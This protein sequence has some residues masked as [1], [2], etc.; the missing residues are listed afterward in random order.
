MVAAANAVQTALQTANQGESDQ[1]RAQ[2]AAMLQWM[3][4]TMARGD[5]GQDQDFGQGVTTRAREIE[6]AAEQICTSADP[7][8]D[9]D[10]DPD[11]NAD[12]DPDPDPRRCPGAEP[13]RC[14]RPG[15]QVAAR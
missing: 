2:V 15:R 14:R 4:A 12:P 1:I 11:S 6:G 3:Q 8:S 7:D 10:P 13:E 5:L 9:P